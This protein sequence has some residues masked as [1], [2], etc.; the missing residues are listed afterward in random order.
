MIK[1]VYYYIH[2]E[3]EIPS[4]FFTSAYMNLPALNFSLSGQGE[5]LQEGAEP[6]LTTLPLSKQ[7]NQ[8]FTQMSRLERGLGGK[9]KNNNMV[10]Y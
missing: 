3:D 7:I 4:R 5:I 1:S 10:E 8:G 6:P 9:V 2:I